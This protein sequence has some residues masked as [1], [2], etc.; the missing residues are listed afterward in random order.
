M[1]APLTPGHPDY[2]GAPFSVP[3]KAA[4]FPRPDVARAQGLTEGNLPFPCRAAGVP[5]AAITADRPSHTS[6]VLLWRAT[7]P[8]PALSRASPP[9]AG[10]ANSTP[11]RSARTR[12][13]N[14]SSC[15]VSFRAP[16][17]SSSGLST[18]TS[19]FALS[20][21]RRPAHV[22]PPPGLARETPSKESENRGPVPLAEERPDIGP[23]IKAD[24]GPILNRFCWAQGAKR[25]ARV[26]GSAGKMTPVREIC[27]RLSQLRGPAWSSS[28]PAA[29]EEGASASAPGRLGH[30]G[31][32]GPRH[33]AAA[34]QSPRPRRS[35]PPRRTT[36]ALPGCSLGHGLV[37]FRAWPFYF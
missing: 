6:T 15:T 18:R 25:S 13:L 31:F 11:H 17:F 30:R 34:C 5:R 20:A 21:P 26:P 19:P 4:P 33:P 3:R 14:N 24:R 35:G 12:R 9:P 37:P 1:V 36:H 29:M 28:R 8:L 2:H 23:S 16:P 22:D 32:P 10:H 7:R 27:D